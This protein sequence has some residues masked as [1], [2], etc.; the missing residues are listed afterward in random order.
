MSAST[1][2]VGYAGAVQLALRADL[3]GPGGAETVDIQRLCD[4]RIVGRLA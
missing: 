1:L 2:L 3:C 4:S